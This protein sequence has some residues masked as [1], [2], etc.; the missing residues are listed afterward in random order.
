MKM[1]IQTLLHMHV[2]F[3]LPNFPSRFTFESEHHFRPHVPRVLLSSRNRSFTTT[4][5]E[6]TLIMNEVEISSQIDS[7][8]EK[9]SRVLTQCRMSRVEF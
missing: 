2:P 3:A 6:A 5:S 9:T 7:C 8:E 4:L 1:V